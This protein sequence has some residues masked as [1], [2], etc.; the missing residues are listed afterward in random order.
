MTPNEPGD[1]RGYGNGSVSSRI[2]NMMV[3]LFTEYTGRGPTKARTYM[4][5]DLISIVLRET[6]TKAERRLVDCG[7][8]ENVR[9][10]RRLFQD[11]MRDDVVA[12]VEQ[13]TGRKV[14]A[15]LSD[16]HID[17]DV[18][19]ETILLRPR[20]TEEGPE[21]ESSDGAPAVLGG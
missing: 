20:P 6:L 3:G 4:Q 1:A 18:A 7:H 16:N 5:E 9:R 12:G 21:T 2:S 10:T 13:I 14:A 19:V 8:L 15:F 17:P 11:V